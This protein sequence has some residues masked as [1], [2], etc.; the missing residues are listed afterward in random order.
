MKITQVT[1]RNVFLTLFQSNTYKANVREFLPWDKT[2]K[3]NVLGNVRI[4][5]HHVKKNM[6]YSL[7]QLERLYNAISD[8]NKT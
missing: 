6:I 4:E 5:D 3:R 7:G 2:D 1:W 8:K